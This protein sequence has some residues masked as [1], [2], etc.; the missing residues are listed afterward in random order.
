[1]T[2]RMR[3]GL[4]AVHGLRWPAWERRRAGV[5]PDAHW[6]TAVRRLYASVAAALVL[7]ILA[8]AG[9]QVQ[10]GL[11]R[12]AHSHPA[13]VREASFVQAASFSTGRPLGSTTLSL[14]GPVARGHLLVGWFA[15]YGAQA[16]VQVADGVNGAW[17]RA[18]RSL[19]FQNEGG[20][21]ALY[22]RENSRAA[23]RGL[24]V[25]VSAAGPAYLQGTAAEYSGVALAGPLDGEAV[26]RGVGTLVHP[27][28]A[29]AAGAGDL[30]FGAVITGRG[31]VVVSPGRSSSKG[32]SPRST[33]VT[34]SAF[35]EDVLASGRGG[36][37]AAAA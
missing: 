16:P 14:G 1:M 25:T 5:R 12:P 18:D 28:P 34:G 6:G 24:T 31:P 26:A 37:A 19:T 8:I 13:V 29:R 2:W 7:S 33:T 9:T 17:N 15:E 30:V 21:I 36:Q 32:F 20:D 35:A 23:P 27:E 4:T 22:Y 11:F 10:A 3:H